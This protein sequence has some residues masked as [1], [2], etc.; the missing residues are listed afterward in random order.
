M[1]AC[2]HQQRSGLRLPNGDQPAVPWAVPSL[3]FATGCNALKRGTPSNTL[4]KTKETS[5]LESNKKAAIDGHS[6]LF[7]IGAFS[8]ASQKAESAPVSSH[9]RHIRLD[10]PLSLSLHFWRRFSGRNNNGRIISLRSTSRCGRPGRWRRWPTARQSCRIWY[11]GC[12]QHVQARLQDE[13]KER[14]GPAPTFIYY[15][16]E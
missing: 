16:E 14:R 3:H 4:R 10:L 1:N 13:I 2:W 11:H 8:E 9:L 12:F 5:K 15:A 7:N 6:K